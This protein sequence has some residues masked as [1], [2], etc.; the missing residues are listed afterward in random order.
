MTYLAD[1]VEVD[2]FHPGVKRMGFIIPWGVINKRLENK[3]LTPFITPSSQLSEATSLFQAV[4]HP[5]LPTFRSPTNNRTAHPHNTSS[6]HAGS[7]SGSGIRQ[8]ASPQRA[9]S[10][11]RQHGHYIKG[12]DAPVNRPATPQE[13]LTPPP[14]L[15]YVSQGSHS[16]TPRQHGE[17][18]HD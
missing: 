4:L 18:S 5:F 17:A 3:R 14:N 12:D 10:F 9:L 6:N 11:S 15:D 13:G 2:L 16:T 7:S 8:P 1:S